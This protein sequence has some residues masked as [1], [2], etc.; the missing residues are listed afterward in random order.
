MNE[1]E[2]DYTISVKLQITHMTPTLNRST[3]TAMPFPTKKVHLNIAEQ[4]F[5]K[6]KKQKQKRK[7]FRIAKTIS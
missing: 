4:Y 6:D 3:L 2:V 5:S 7:D 1:P